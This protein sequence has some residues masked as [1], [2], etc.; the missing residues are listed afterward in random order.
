[1]NRFRPLAFMVSIL[2][3]GC[4]A[5]AF[6]M[7]PPEPSPLSPDEKVQQTMEALVGRPISKAIQKW[8]VPH[9]LTDD[10]TGSRIYIWQVPGQEFLAPQDNRILS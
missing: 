6:L 10:A 2:L 1:M 3:A 8:G 7:N 4:T 9:G 5:P